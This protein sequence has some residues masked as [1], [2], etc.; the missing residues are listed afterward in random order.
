MRCQHHINRDRSYL[1][2]FASSF[3]NSLGHHVPKIM[4]KFGKYQNFK[5]RHKRKQILIFQFRKVQI[6]VT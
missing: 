3:G 4:G 2:N 1:L 6:N 5:Y